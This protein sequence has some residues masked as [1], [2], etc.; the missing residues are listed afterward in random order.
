MGAQTKSALNIIELSTSAEFVLDA[1]KREGQLIARIYRLSHLLSN[2]D[3]DPDQEEQIKLILEDALAELDIL[4][5]S[6][7]LE[8][9]INKTLF[10]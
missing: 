8:F 2:G 7:N 9:S 10:H 3:L 4:N 5:E 1:K 6:S